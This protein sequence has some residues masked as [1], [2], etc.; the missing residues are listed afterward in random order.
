[1]A[2]LI[3]PIPIVLDKPRHLYYDKRAVKQ[4][5]RALER[6]WGPNCTFYSVLSDLTQLALTGN[7]GFLSFSKLAIVLWQ[8]LVHD[9]PTLTL[10][11]VEDALPVMDIV[12]LAGYAG[13][14]LAA[15]M[16]MSPSVVAGTE[17]ANDRDPL[18]A[19][20]GPISGAL[21]AE[22]SG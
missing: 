10:A 6:E 16:Q 18:G 2:E 5:E 11:Q 4:A 21:N 17:A 12:A 19:S 3:D 1:M 15:W 9:D 22:F 14:V 8:G 13:N 7:P 20:P